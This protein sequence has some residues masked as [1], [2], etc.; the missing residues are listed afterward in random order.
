MICEIGSLIKWYDYYHDNNVVRDSGLGLVLKIQKNKYFDCI[1]YV[2]FRNKY[3]DTMFFGEHE[4][5]IFV[6]KEIKK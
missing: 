3:N 1:N 6:E 2:I 4:I 5:E